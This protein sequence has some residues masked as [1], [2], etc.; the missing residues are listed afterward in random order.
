MIYIKTKSEHLCLIRT[1]L[2][3]LRDNKIYVGQYKFE[4]KQSETEFLGSIVGIDGIRIGE[5]RGKVLRDWPTPSRITELSGF[6]GPIQF[7]LRFIRSVF[8]IA[9]PLTNLTRIRASIKHRDAK[10]DEA[11][12][13]LRERLISAP[14]MM[15]PNCGKLF[16]CLTDASQ[17]E[18]GGTLTQYNDKKE[19]RGISSFSKRLSTAE[20]NY[21][22]NDREHLGVLK[23]A[24]SRY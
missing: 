18:V 16:S 8:D 19:D 7:F 12:A 21:S 20:E 24:P 14:V 9:A 10:C 6:V 5:E 15:A 11:S 3:R 2:E 23:E 22:A 17:R 4:L 1:V 13:R